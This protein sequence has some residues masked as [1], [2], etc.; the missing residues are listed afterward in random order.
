MLVLSFRIFDVSPQVG[1]FGTAINDVSSYPILDNRHNLPEVTTEE[2]W[3]AA[4]RYLWT[5]DIL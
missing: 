5:S 1:L 2:S 3:N 4:H